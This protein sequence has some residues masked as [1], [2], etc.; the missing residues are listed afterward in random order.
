MQIIAL[1]KYI[2]GSK[3]TDYYWDTDHTH[4]NEQGNKIWAKI[5][6]EFLLNPNNKL[7]PRLQK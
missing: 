7:I 6:L 4:F 5:Q 3:Q 1:K 2:V